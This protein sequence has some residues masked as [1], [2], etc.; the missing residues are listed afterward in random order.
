MFLVKCC[1]TS[2]LHTDPVSLTQEK[3]QA[4]EKVQKRV[5]EVNGKPAVQKETDCDWSNEV[6]ESTNSCSIIYCMDKHCR[7]KNNC[8]S[9]RK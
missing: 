3:K 4:R 5:A 8:L 7:E 9:S 1:Q 2:A 6:Q